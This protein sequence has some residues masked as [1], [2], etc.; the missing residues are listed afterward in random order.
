MW[1]SRGPVGMRVLGISVAREALWDGK[2]SQ[3]PGN[4]FQERSAGAQILFL[5]G[6][7]SLLCASVAAF[8]LA[9]VNE[10]WC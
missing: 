6:Q 5:E 7:S 4:T 10:S 2:E 3:T 9:A 1:L 8:N